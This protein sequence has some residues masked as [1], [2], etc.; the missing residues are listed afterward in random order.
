MADAYRTDLAYIHDAAYGKYAEHAAPVLL[1]ALKRARIPSGLVIDL[2]CG[3]GI[4]TERVAAAGFDVL[5][6]DISPAMIALARK[7]VPKARFQVAS[8]VDAAL[9]PCVAVAAIG[10]VVNYCFDPE[11]S[12]ATIRNLFRRVHDA[13]CPRG[14]FLFDFAERGRGSTGLPPHGRAGADWAVI[15]EGQEDRQRG[16]LTRRI[17]TFRKVGKH[18]R[19]DE[20]THV[21]RLLRRKDVMRELRPIGFR[22]RLLRNYGS[23]RLP[24]G[25]TAI[26]ARKPK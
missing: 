20:E 14:L 7:R 4:L 11:N 2:G 12:D 3:S 22:V 18:Y 5:G 13:L 6:L 26:L 16:L 25:W 21:Q 24:R 8:F 10:E 17:T 1:S 9:P 15:A 23:V 19:R